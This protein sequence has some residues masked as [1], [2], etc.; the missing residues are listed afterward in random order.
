MKEYYEALGL[1]EKAAPEMIEFAFTDLKKKYD[2]DKFSGKQ[3]EEAFIKLK[4]IT[5]A[6][7]VIKQTFEHQIYEENKSM[8]LKT[9][10]KKIK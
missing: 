4:E 7:N 10:P 6:Y 8:K 1:H 3:K 2:P 5:D 9:I